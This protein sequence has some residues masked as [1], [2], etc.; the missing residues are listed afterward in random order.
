MTPLH[1]GSAGG[2]EHHCDIRCDSMRGGSSQSAAAASVGGR[3]FP[4]LCKACL[5]PPH[6]Q[7]APPSELTRPPL[8]PSFE[9][10]GGNPFRLAAA[11]RVGKHDARGAA[12]ALLTLRR[13]RVRNDDILAGDGLAA[14]LASM[15]RL[16][17]GLRGSQS[18]MA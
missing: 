6:L 12:A 5:H 11:I 8:L 10:Q 3:E 7:P 1:A 2:L 14:G 4:V 18:R 16:R 9:V 15:F 13:R 17:N